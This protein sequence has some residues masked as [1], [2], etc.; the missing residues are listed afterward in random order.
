MSAT[1]HFRKTTNDSFS[2]NANR[3][4]GDL[5][6]GHLDLIN[7]Y[8]GGITT[9]VNWGRRTYHGL[10]LEVN[11]RFA[12]GWQL[13]GSYTHNNSRSNYGGTEAFNP[14]LDWARDEIATNAFKMSAVWDLPFL[15][16][17]K[18]AVGSILGGWQLSTLWNFESGR[19]FNPVSGAAYG[20]GGDFNADGQRSD[21]PD[22]PPGSVARSYSKSAWMNGALSASIFPLP[23]TIR[24][25]TLPRNYFRGPGYAR[26]D[27]SFTKRFTIKERVTIQYQAQASNLLNRVNIASVSS[28]LTAANFG[29]AS[30][31]YPMRTLQMGVKAIF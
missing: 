28:S 24:D 17:R 25:G 7:P 9:F 18:G 19:Y 16:T 8:Y 30:G 1:Y 22:R 31:F 10:I 3:L 2:F 20:S 13:N 29:M 4:A 26:I 21:R 11:K 15:R 23:D 6:D 14:A 5:A 12:Q 27:A